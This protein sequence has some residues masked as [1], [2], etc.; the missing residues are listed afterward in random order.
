MNDLRAFLALAESRGHLLRLSRPVDAETEAGALLIELERQGKVG[1]FEHLSGRDGRLAGN[2]LGRR[3][4]LAA[5]LGVAIDDVVPTYQERLAAARAS[6][7]VRGR[8]AACAGGSCAAKTQTC[9]GAAHRARHWGRGRVH[10]RR[11]CAGTRSGD[12]AAQRLDQPNAAQ[13]RPQGGHSHDAAAA[14]RRAA[15]QRGG[16]GL[17]LTGRRRDWQ[18]PAGPGGGG[19]HAAARRRRAGAGGVAARV[20]VRARAGGVAAR[21]AGSRVRGARAGGVRRAGRASPRA[22]LA[23][24]CSTTC[25]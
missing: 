20:A 13:G 3:D 5:V 10:H 24:S 15:G 16:N 22:R 6:R 11:D 8:R 23:T 1:L 18:S 2:L 9:A 17:A 12:L 19:H 4:L 14:A 21:L 25:R 7:A